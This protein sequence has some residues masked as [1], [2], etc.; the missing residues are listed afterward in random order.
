MAVQDGA[1][2]QAVPEGAAQVADVHAAVALALAA[3]PGQQ[4]AP[5]PRHEPRGARDRLRAPPGSGFTPRPDSGRFPAAAPAPTPAPLRAAGA[6]PRAAGAGRGGG[7]AAASVSALGLR[8][9]VPAGLAAPRPALPGPARA[10]AARVAR[11]GGPPP[12]HRRPPPSLWA[13]RGRG[14]PAGFGPRP[15][16][17]GAGA[18]RPTQRRLRPQTRP[19]PPEGRTPRSPS[20][21]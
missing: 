8:R 16:P 1:E 4:R 9:G 15:P 12:T 10:A 13:G 18:W 11:P 20:A 17:R 14:R 5:R 3:A 19:R 7:G 6:D 2:G 21:G